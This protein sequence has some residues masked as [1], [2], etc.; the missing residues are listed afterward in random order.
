MQEAEAFVMNLAQ[1]AWKS[2][3]EMSRLREICNGGKPRIANWACAN[4]AL[5]CR[6]SHSGVAVGI[7]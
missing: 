5:C 7:P 4:L 6:P 1:T 2:K 3:W